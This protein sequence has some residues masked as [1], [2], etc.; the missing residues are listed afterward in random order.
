MYLGFYWLAMSNAM[1]NPVIYYWMNSR[2][3]IYFREIICFC[4][5]RLMGTSIAKHKPTRSML[6]KKPSH[7]ELARSKSG[8]AY[9]KKTQFKQKSNK[10]YLFL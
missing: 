5:I 3:R 7:S 4:C 1:V 10:I 9:T 2:F 8:K 6:N